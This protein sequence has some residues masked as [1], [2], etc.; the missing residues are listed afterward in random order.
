MCRPPEPDKIGN[1]CQFIPMAVEL[2]Q[3]AS[4][5]KR[6][7]ISS[8]ATDVFSARGVARTSMAH[9]AEEA[10]MSRPALYQYFENK[11][12]IFACD[13]TA[14]VEGSADSALAA[15]ENPGSVAEQLEGFLQDFS[16]AFWE[17]TA[18]SPYV[19]ELLSAKSAFAPQ[20]VGAVM[21]RIRRD[22]ERY[23]K[24]VGPKG[25]FCGDGRT[26][27]RLDRSAGVFASRFQAR[28]TLKRFVSPSPNSTLAKPRRRYRSGSRLRRLGCVGPILASRSI[29]L[30]AIYD[31]GASIGSPIRA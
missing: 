24:R 15:L 1:E 21:V 11:G 5:P 6:A 16:G 2:K 28:Q 14:L 13:F 19:N 25:A 22:L 30:M 31:A 8:A 26:P 12:D 10:G 20:A 29:E 23:L 17:R 7:A 27:Q 3:I 9:I 18:A 4:D